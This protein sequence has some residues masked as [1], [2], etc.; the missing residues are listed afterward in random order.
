MPSVLD[1]IIDGV[2]ADLAVRQ[3]RTSLEQLKSRTES[4]GY[5]LR[6]RLPVYP[7]FLTSLTSRRGLLAEKV[8]AAADREGYA[9]RGMAA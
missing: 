1:E 7:E 4:R 3:S 9:G 8:Q 2:R 5:I 6:Q